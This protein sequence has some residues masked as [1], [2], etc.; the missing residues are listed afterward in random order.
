MD[1][2]SFQWLFSDTLL[3]TIE[4]AAYHDLY[5]GKLGPTALICGVTLEIW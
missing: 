1:K 2:G 3:L 5:Y 4:D